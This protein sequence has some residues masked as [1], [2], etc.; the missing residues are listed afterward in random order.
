MSANYIILDKN[1]TQYRPKR[2]RH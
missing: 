2:T 1:L